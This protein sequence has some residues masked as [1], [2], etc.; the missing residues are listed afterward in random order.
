MAISE[1]WSLSAVTVGSTELSIISGTTVLQ[2]NTTAGVYQLF[3]DPVTNMAKS[4]QFKVRIYEKVKAGTKRVVFSQL[5]TNTQSE[6]L[7]FPSMILMNGFDFTI[8]K[9][10]GTDR[11]FDASV[12]KI[13]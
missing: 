1:A 6:N 11:A 13:A 9:V 7:V 12:R 10:N 2:T 4:D 8:Q 5:I 3:V